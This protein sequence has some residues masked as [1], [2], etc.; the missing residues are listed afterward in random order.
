PSAAAVPKIL[1]ALDASSPA[2]GTPTA[3][4]LRRA[5]DY[6]TKGEGATLKG[7]R[8]VL[9]ATDG[10]PNCDSTLSC[11]AAT[12]TTNLDGTCSIP[13]GASCC[14]PQFGG[15]AA[16][17]RCLDDAGTE[18]QIKALE[19]AGVHTFV[20]GIPGS[21]VYGDALDAFAIAGGEALTQ[22]PRKY[23]AV[24]ASGGV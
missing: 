1:S 18:A 22:G 4:A 5:L 10:G 11:T 14:D 24:A 2:G 23:F 21:E 19:T 9:L 8:Y 16:R 12:C 3:E 20:V 17:S 6:F 13:A 7:N 15:A